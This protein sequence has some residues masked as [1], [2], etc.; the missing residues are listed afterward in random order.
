MPRLPRQLEFEVMAHTHPV[1]GRLRRTNVA[2]LEKRAANSVSA[3]Q[4]EGQN[5]QPVSF[6]PMK[7]VL[8]VS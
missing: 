5:P 2:P 7:E 8:C 4:I 6:A 1:S 3:G